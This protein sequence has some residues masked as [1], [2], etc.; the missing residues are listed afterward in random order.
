MSIKRILKLTFILSLLFSL[1]VGLSSC[2]TSR[3][4]NKAIK[5]M[6]HRQ[7]KIDD[8]FIKEYD[9][10]YKRQTK[11]QNEQQRKMIEKSRKNPKNMGKK[12]RFFLFQYCFH[13]GE[14]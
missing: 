9:K 6:E 10:K 4:E 12:K 2:R 7:R 11:L 14:S 13:N 8:Q 5:E 3:V 1:G